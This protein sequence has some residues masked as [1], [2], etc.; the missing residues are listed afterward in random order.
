[1]GEAG[2]VFLKSPDAGF[3]GG[4][5]VVEDSHFF[6]ISAEKLKKEGV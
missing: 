2:A 1:M 5:C 4:L 3:I 6:K